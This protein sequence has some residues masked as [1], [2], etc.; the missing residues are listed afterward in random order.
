[1]SAALEHTSSKTLRYFRVIARFAFIHKPGS[2]VSPL[3]LP[4][5]HHHTSCDGV[6]K[7]FWTE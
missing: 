5:V 4:P 3:Q 1:M 6:C 7:W 2:D